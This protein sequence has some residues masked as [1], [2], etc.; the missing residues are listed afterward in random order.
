[1]DDFDDVDWSDQIEPVSGFTFNEIFQSGYDQAVID[2]K[3][4]LNVALDVIQY[5]TKKNRELEAV[6]AEFVKG[7][8]DG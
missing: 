5:L 3:A 8:L 1:M 7:G 4:T 2:D 6:V